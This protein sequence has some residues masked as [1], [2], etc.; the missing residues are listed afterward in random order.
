MLAKQRYI[1]FSLLYAS[2]ALHPLSDDVV[3]WVSLLIYW[4]TNQHFMVGP[5]HGCTV[6]ERDRKGIACDGRMMQMC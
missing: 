6:L 4:K 1:V 5:L 3:T 2:K